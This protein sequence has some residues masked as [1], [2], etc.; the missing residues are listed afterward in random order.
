[1]PEFPVEALMELASR[2][3]RMDG[4]KGTVRCVTGKLRRCTK[5]RV[6]LT[7]PGRPKEEED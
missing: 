1:M 6:T 2:C 5:V 4:A 7:I 3:L